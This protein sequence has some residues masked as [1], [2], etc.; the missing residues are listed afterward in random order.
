[1]SNVIFT[2]NEE[3]ALTAGQGGFINESGAYV[4]TLTEAALKTFDSGSKA[5]EFS[6]ETDDGRKVQ[7]LSVFT[8]KTDGTESKFGTA[9]VQAIMGCA[10]I[11]QATYKM[12]DAQ[13][14]I[15]PEFAGKQVGLVL[16]KI[17][18]SKQDGSDS[19]KMEIKLPFIAATRQTLKEKSDGKN[20]ETVD[21]MISGLKDK[22]ERKKGGSN[23]SN[24]G[25]YDQY[26]Q[27]DDGFSPF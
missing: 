27:Q 23:A 1:M 20:A 9:I 11:K 24:S 2:Y 6:G 26:A 10:G 8:T 25:G 4:V 12:L 17:L 18:T 7:Y 16:Q 3:S 14:L 5:V 15:S 13:H 22:D 21:R 19:Y